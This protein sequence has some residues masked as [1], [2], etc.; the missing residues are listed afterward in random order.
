MKGYWICFGLFYSILAV[1]LGLAVTAE[2]L[3]RMLEEE[4]NITLVD[5]RY[6]NDYANNHIQGAI[7][8]PARACRL[9]NLPPLGRII[10]Y[11]DGVDTASAA[12]AAFFLNQKPGITAEILE[13]GLG[14][15]E[16]LQY[17]MSVKRGMTREELPAITY[18]SLTSVYK[19]NTD[20]I[21]VDLRRFPEG[22][23]D[24]RQTSQYKET[25][26]SVTQSGNF[27]DISEQFPGA[28]IVSSLPVS[29]SKTASGARSIQS[30]IPSS[31]S[32]SHCYVLIDNCDGTAEKTAR[33][34]KARGI[35]RFV[36]LTGG[37]KI[38]SRK[39]KSGIQRLNG[40]NP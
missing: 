8:I 14:R 6:K 39:G 3:S 29:G 1:N 27:T 18:D 15:W 2:D 25:K 11:G 5:T 9:K 33:R 38:L 31:D 7:N 22:T 10:V 13:G 30:R 16:T 35:H 26:T 4:G 40:G 23:T 34:M 21:F 24:V 37:E 28:T 32:G 36:I 12:Q 20:L 19:K 17:P